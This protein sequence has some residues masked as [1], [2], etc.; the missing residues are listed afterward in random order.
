MSPLHTRRSVVAKAA[1][2]PLALALPAT[3]A[4]S[5]PAASRRPRTAAAFADLERRFDAR[6]GLHAIDTATGRT[7]SHRTGERFAFCST[8]KALASALLLRDADLDH[9]VRYTAADLVTYSPI[10]EQHVDTGMTIRALCDAALRYSDNTAHNLVLGQL[11]GPA[12]FTRGLR[13]RLGDRVTR[14][15][16][17]EPALNS[18]VPGEVLD[19]TTPEAI[20]TSLGRCVLGR[21]LPCDRRAILRDLMLRNTTGDG[22]IRGGVPSTWEVADKTGSGS[23]AS[24]ND[25]AVL[26]PPRRRPIVLAVLTSRPRVDDVRDIALIAEATEVA[27]GALR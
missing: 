8:S 10:T 14:S 26:W 13:R 7:V 3:A 12:G 24:S 9:V 15:D 5:A 1:L 2:V 27:V 11:G 25:I 16:R 23:Y 4:P 6:V 18:A 22:Q 21:V 20:A 19:T 17:F